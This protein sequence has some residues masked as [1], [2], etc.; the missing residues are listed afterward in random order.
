MTG[1]EE[2]P[3]HALR[4]ELHRRLYMLEGGPGSRSGAAAVVGNGTM[5]SG[6]DNS[7]TVIGM[8]NTT[9]G[10]RNETVAGG[11]TTGNGTNTGVSPLDIQAATNGGVTV[12]KP[13][14]TN[15]S[16]GLNIE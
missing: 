13:P 9:T 1:R 11:G 14:T 12:A 15:D 5:G 6:M 10:T 4:S 2:P 3:E 7:T 16:L 8:G